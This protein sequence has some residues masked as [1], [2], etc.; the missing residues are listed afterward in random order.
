[1]CRGEIA[2]RG[3]R[4]GDEEEISRLIQKSFR[5]YIAHTYKPEGLANFLRETSPGGMRERLDADQLIIVAEHRDAGTS[6]SIVGVIAVR[7][8]NHISL[9][10]VDDLYH[11]R[12]IAQELVS[13]A[14]AT[15]RAGEPEAGCVTVYSSPYA[16]PFYN[17]LGFT[18][19]GP[20]TFERGML[21]TPMKLAL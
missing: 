11:R 8:G 20:Q 9:L 13:R 12:G 19:E 18:S 21:V 17:Q 16:V 14:I 15:I 4:A 2:Y 7:R 3:M 6:G 1:M 10:F 5:T